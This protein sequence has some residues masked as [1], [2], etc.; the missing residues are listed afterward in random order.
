MADKK[1]K[2][3]TIDII[4]PNYNS[5]NFI[6]ETIKSIINQSFKN[7][8]LI[9]VDDCSNKQ[10][11]KI[12][13][14]FSKNKRIKIYWLKKNYGAGFCRNYAIKKSKSTY[15]AFI[16]SDDIWKKDKLETQLRFMEENNYFFTYTSYETFGNKFKYV[17]PPLEY[18]KNLFTI[19]QFV[20]V[21]C[22]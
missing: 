6:N 18:T 15:I 7:W 20:L 21:Q 9:I 5:F 2:K 3:I 11:A 14:K 1:K 12:L 4:L 13:K 22:Y 10:T 16:D 19:H 17:K 8:K